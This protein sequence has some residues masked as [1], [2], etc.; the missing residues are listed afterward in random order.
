MRNSSL[1]PQRSFGLRIREL[2]AA[3]PLTQEE[4]AEATGLF[5]TYI[6]RVEAGLANPTLGVI[7]QFARALDVEVAELFVPPKGVA[8]RVRSANPVSRGRVG[9]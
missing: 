7:H 8:P 3:A 2:R 1:T 5:R 6:S 9:R 4:L